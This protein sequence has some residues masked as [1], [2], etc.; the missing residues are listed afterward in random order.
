MDGYIRP[1]DKN[2]LP[3]DHDLTPESIQN[4]K[5]VKAARAK[6]QKLA[7]G[8][9]MSD[10]A[11][12][13]L[14]SSHATAENQEVLAN[15][16]A[17]SKS[18]KNVRHRPTANTLRHSKLTQN[19]A[20]QSVAD[21][22]EQARK[23]ALDPNL[24]YGRARRHGCTVDVREMF[25]STRE[26]LPENDP[27]G[28]AIKKLMVKYKLL[29]PSEAIR[30]KPMPNRRSN[31]KGDDGKPKKKRYYEKKRE[32]ITN[33]HLDGDAVGEYLREKMHEIK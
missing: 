17:S 24:T 19:T 13:T 4:L 22:I 32:R 11:I 18:M 16:V 3:L 30:R 1:F 2:H 15:A 7:M 5:A 28:S 8:S 9:R 27:D 10:G 25:L 6:L 12:S 26:S 31:N 20:P 29:D 21:H 33:K 14:L 23:A